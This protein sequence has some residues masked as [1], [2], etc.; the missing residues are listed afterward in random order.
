MCVIENDFYMSFKNVPKSNIF[1]NACYNCTSRKLSQEKDDDNDN[2]DV[3]FSGKTMSRR[4]FLK[5]AMG[6]GIGAAA[7]AM[8]GGAFLGKMQ[9]L[10]APTATYAQPSGEVGKAINLAVGYQ[11]Y[12]TCNFDASAL[13]QAQ[14]WKKYL[15]KGSNVEWFEA[16]SGALLNNNLVAGKN[17]IIY[18]CDTP[19]SRTFDTSPSTCITIQSMEYAHPAWLVDTLG[20]KPVSGDMKRTTPDGS[21]EIPKT[22]MS[23]VLVRTDLLKSGKVKTFADLKGMKVGVPHGS[24]SHRQIKLLEKLN[25]APVTLLDQSIELHVAQLRAKHVDAVLTWGPYPGWIERQGLAQILISAPE[26][27]C[28]CNTGTHFH[29]EGLVVGHDKVVKERPDVV[30]AW[31]QAEEDARE[32]LVQDR[33]NGSQ[34]MLDLVMKDTPEVPK[35]AVK[36][37]IEELAPEG[38]PYYDKH[39]EHYKQ[40]SEEWRKLGILRGQKSANMDNFVNKVV[41]R[42]DV[43]QIF[44]E[45]IEEREKQGKYHSGTGEIMNYW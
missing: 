21:K 24:Y 40:I 35:D 36:E 27:Q 34:R 37:A 45:V 26:H 5:L 7:M 8:G 42:P 6:A 32:I 15:P 30:K 16:L 11:P 18:A 41:F 9:Q 3:S 2:D 43:K 17:Q 10:V 44:D 28:V 33:A 1:K 14:L 31:I 19:A 4:D 20:R 25:D 12:C 39:L 38:Y 22:Y 13:R 29:M 23:P